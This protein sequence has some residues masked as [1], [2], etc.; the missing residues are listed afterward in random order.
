M[1]APGD[2]TAIGGKSGGS[3]DSALEKE[4]QKFLEAL[5]MF[6]VDLGKIA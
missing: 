1:P 4:L 3:N 2:K 5:V 6:E